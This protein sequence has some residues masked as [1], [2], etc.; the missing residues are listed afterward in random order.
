MCSFRHIRIN[1]SSPSIIIIVQYKYHRRHKTSLWTFILVKLWKILNIY[2]TVKSIA[3]QTT[4]VI[5]ELAKN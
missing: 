2:K 4:V 5:Q 1:V 3:S